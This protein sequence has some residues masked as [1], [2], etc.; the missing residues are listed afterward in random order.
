MGSPEA[1]WAGDARAARLARQASIATEY[2]TADDDDLLY[3]RRVLNAELGERG[4][5]TEGD[6]SGGLVTLT[7]TA[8]LGLG[9]GLCFGTAM[10][11][12]LVW[13]VTL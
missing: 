13:L 10:F 7:I 9:I 5:C 2:A 12:V 1:F 11:Q 3:A 6:A 4:Y 8:I